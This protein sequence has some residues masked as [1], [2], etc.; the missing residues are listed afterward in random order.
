[1]VMEA[2]LEV[3]AALVVEESSI[4]VITASVVAAGMA[5]ADLVMVETVLE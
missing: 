4:K 5:T 2:S 3:V 1:M